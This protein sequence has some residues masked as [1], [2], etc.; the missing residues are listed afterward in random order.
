MKEEELREEYVLVP[1]KELRR[2]EATEK[3]T[4]ALLVS[5]SAQLRALREEVAA[6]RGALAF[7]A[8]RASWRPRGFSGIVLA[9]L[10]AG[11]KARTARNEP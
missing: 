6:L 7:Y 10:D 8:D 3:S 11:K 1:A 4:S 2:L 5:G 9:H